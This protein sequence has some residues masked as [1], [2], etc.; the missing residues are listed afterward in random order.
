MLTLS[1]TDT[2]PLKREAF[3]AYFRTANGKGTVN[4]LAF[5]ASDW[6]FRSPSLLV[7]QRPTI[8]GGGFASHN[9]IV[10]LA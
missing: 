10:T 1:R 7:L 8:L 4:L 2:D 9:S 5:H 3:D 6:G